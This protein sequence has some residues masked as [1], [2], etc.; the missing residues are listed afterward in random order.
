[1]LQCLRFHHKQSTK[2]FRT[3]KFNRHGVRSY[4]QALFQQNVI[5]ASVELPI[6]KRCIYSTGVAE[7]VAAAQ[8]HSQYES[9]I[10]PKS[11]R[12]VIC[13]GGV[14]GGK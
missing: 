2:L 4:S 7:N 14:M 11:A 5:K 6:L 9:N 3:S 10:L 8:E 12:V 13:G 1:M